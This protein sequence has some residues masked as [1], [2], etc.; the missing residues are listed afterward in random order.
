MAATGEHRHREER[1]RRFETR[2][3]DLVT[4]EMPG[5]SVSMP[6][7]SVTESVCERWCA[8]CGAWIEV[9]GVLGAL[10]F[11]FEHRHEGERST[12]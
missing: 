8:R 10:A 11:E 4:Y 12:P 3:G 6:S 7:G 9:R 1:K 2:V 5:G